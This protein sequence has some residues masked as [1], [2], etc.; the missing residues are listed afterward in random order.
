[1][2]EAFTS[3]RPYMPEWMAQRGAALLGSLPQEVEQWVRE[4]AAEIEPLA[5]P[6]KLDAWKDEI[7]QRFCG[8]CKASQKDSVVGA[9]RSAVLLVAI[10]QMPAPEIMPG[11]Q[12]AVPSESKTKKMGR[13]ALKRSRMLGMLEKGLQAYNE[14]TKAAVEAIGR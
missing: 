1:M 11:Q 14:A 9:L 10:R 13:V 4:A 12:T 6:P 5:G 2:S 7:V 8:G 3:L